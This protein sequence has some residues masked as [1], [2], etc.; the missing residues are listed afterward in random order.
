MGLLRA[1]RVV[2]AQAVVIAILG[3]LAG[4]LLDYDMRVLPL[5]GLLLPW[6]VLFGNHGLK[7]KAGASG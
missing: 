2:A 6:L 5:L 4:H 1:G 3:P 7:A